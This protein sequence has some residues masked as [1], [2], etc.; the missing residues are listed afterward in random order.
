[1]TIQPVK[2]WTL[3]GMAVRTAAMLRNCSKAIWPRNCRLC[4]RPLMTGEKAVCLGCVARLPEIRYDDFLPYVGVPGNQIRV[5]SWFVY[6]HDDVS[7]TLIHD[8]KYHDCRRLAV[9]LGREFAMR[10]LSDDIGI[11]IILPIPLHWTKHFLRGYNQTRE[12]ASGI[13]DITGIKAGGNLYARQPHRAQALS[14]RTMR[15]GNVKDI[16][17]VRSPQELDG[18]HIAILDDVITTGAT[19]F[20][21]LEAVTA[22]S[23]PREIT[24]LSLTRVR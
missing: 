12:I 10:K 8:I 19:M 13:S 18:K 24:F 14:S 7:H 3:R 1:M 23:R 11:D 6:N 21:A 17:A 5:R 2:N 22:A 15:A 9:H 4:D 16:F 20:S